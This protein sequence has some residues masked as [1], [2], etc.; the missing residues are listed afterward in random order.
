M[1]L[2][3]VVERAEDLV[4]ALL[5]ERPRLEGMRIER[6]RVAMALH[7]IGFGLVHQPGRPATATHGVIDPEKRDVQPT[8]PDASEQPTH[9]LAAIVPEEEIHRIV[10]RHTGDADIV[11]DEMIAHELRCRAAFLL[12]DDLEIGYGK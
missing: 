11:K 12:E 8:T 4:T 10:G 5:V 1:A 7:G 6:G 2:G 9:R 3:V